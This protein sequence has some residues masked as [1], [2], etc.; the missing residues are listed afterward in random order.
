MQTQG[1]GEKK[2]HS[3]TGHTSEKSETQDPDPRDL[4]GKINST[5]QIEENLAKLRVHSEIRALF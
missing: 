4:K 3:I 5:W 2:S 1:K